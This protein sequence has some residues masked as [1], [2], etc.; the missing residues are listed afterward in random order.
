MWGLVPHRAVRSEGLDRCAVSLRSDGVVP[1]LG[2]HR[3]RVAVDEQLRP[4]PHRFAP[5]SQAVAQPRAALENGGADP[6]G[7]EGAPERG[8]REQRQQQPAAVCHRGRLRG[9]GS[10]S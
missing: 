8:R 6:R 10:C 2:V 9:R 4:A 5:A 1:H 7:G 3:V